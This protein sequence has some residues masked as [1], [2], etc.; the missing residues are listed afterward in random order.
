MAVCVGRVSSPTACC[1]EGGGELNP[2]FLAMMALPPP[3]SPT[4]QKEFVIEEE[5]D[6]KPQFDI[7][8][9]IQESKKVA[10][11]ADDL[12]PPY[13]HP[14]LRR[15]SS[16]LS[17]KSM[18]VC[19]ESLGSETGSNDYY[20][21][22]SEYPDSDDEDAEDDEEDS[23]HIE[24]EGEYFCEYYSLSGKK[25]KELA[26]VN[27]HCSVGKKSPARAFP[28]PLPSISRRDGPC[29][30][31]KPER[32]DGRL[33]VQAV[34]VPSQNYLHCQREEGRLLLTFIEP[35]FEEIY[36]EEVRDCPADQELE[37][38][39]L[40]CDEDEEEEEQ[41]EDEDDVE[42]DGEMEDDRGE[43]VS[44]EEDLEEEAEEEEVEVVDRGTV[45]EVKVSWQPQPQSG[46]GK[47]HRSS[48]VINK[49][50]VGTPAA[51]EMAA[52]AAAIEGGLVKHDFPTKEDAVAPPTAP[53]ESRGAAVAVAAAE[54]DGW[55]T[56][57]RSPMRNRTAVGEDSRL[58][59]FTTKKLM[60]REAL[61]HQ[62][63]RCSYQ[64][65][66]LFIWEP[67]CIATS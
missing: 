27:Y 21:E 57:R 28:P 20:C 16:M 13:V 24:D 51:P 15:S 54:A 25:R 40:S 14:L 10:A 42:D 35:A 63:R 9:S 64:H 32:K 33:V 67:F 12:P 61:L 39:E 59:L 18:D 8:N 60:N 5:E 48:L 31:M 56:G 29:L 23:I 34:P 44:K 53:V 47:V 7:W 6:S 4:S 22:W 58:L 3:L 17:Q 19:T 66:P 46:S 55:G 36:P 45:V 37:E 41:T 2:V 50:V 43:L 62:V 30:H 26:S 65:R 49:F 38:S 11:A 52:A 1:P